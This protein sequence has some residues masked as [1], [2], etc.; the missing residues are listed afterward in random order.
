M[1]D[2]K[3]V[4]AFMQPFFIQKYSQ[5]VG[6][7]PLIPKKY[8]PAPSQYRQSFITYTGLCP[9]HQQWMKQLG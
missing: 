3:D 1:T 7:I 6:N 4:L 5:I 8:M 2:I 9:M